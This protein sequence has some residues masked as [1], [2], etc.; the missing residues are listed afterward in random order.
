MNLRDGLGLSARALPEGEILLRLHLFCPGQRRQ[1]WLPRPTTVRTRR[2]NN[3]Q[4]YTKNRPFLGRLLYDDISSVILDNFLHHS[5]PQS[6]PVF[7]TIAD[8]RFEK[9]A[10]NRLR[11]AATIV[12][13]PNL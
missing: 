9:L 8:E 6:S 4:G 10:S 12:G 5:Q 13:E 2:R 3:G 1:I 7:L 11:N